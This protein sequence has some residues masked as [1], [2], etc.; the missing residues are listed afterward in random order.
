MIFAFFFSLI[1]AVL[2]GFLI[3]FFTYKKLN[4]NANKYP[5]LISI[6][7]FLVSVVVIGIAITGLLISGLHLER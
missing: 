5:W 7:T 6:A 2:A 3:A 4:R 1:I